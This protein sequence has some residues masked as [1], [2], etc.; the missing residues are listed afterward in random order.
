MDTRKIKHQYLLSKWTPIIR[1]CRS[2]GKTV[3][4]W[5]LENNVDEKQ[6]FYWQR[7]VRE[8]LCTSVQTPEK[9][10][11]TIFAPLP[12]QDYQKETPQSELFRPDLI[13]SI[14]DYRLEL[15][16]QTRPELLE[17]ILKVIHHV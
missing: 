5:C 4:A 17:V 9:G 8:E 11:P 2:S 15:A 3:K 14:G 7:R 12:I 16:N 1:E 10:Q 13:I 6:F